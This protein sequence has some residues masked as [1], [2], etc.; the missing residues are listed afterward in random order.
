[1]RYASRRLLHGA[2]VVWA[3]YTVTWLL[4]YLLPSDPVSLMLVG[5]GNSSGQTRAALE[6][7]YGLDRPPLLQY[8]TLLG[9]ALLGD[10]GDSI[11]YGRPVLDVVLGAVPYTIQLGVAAVA[12]SIVVGFGLALLANATR[13]AWLRNILFSLPSAFLSFP[14]FLTGLLLVQIFAFSL[15]LL[16]AVG[17][18]GWQSLVLPALTSGVPASAAIAQVATKSIHEYLDSPQSSYLR[19]R[20]VTRRRILI[21]HALR[22]A[23]I[24]AVTIL[25][26][27]VGG[28]PRRCRHHR[29]RLLPPGPGEGAPERCAQ[30][31]H[32]AGTGRR[33]ALRGAVRP[34]ELPGGSRLSAA[35][36]AHQEGVT[37][38]EG[39]VAAPRAHGPHPLPGGAAR[40]VEQTGAAWASHPVDGAY[41]DECAYRP[42]ARPPVA[43]DGAGSPGRSVLRALFRRRHRA[44]RQGG[45]LSRELRQP[46]L[47]LAVLLLGAVILAAFL[48]GLFA[49]QDPYATDVTD[50][51]AAPSAQHLFGTDGLGRD[52]FSRFVHGT[53]NTLIAS[54]VAVLIG[55][56][57]SSVLG[58]L[59]GYF[60]GVLDETVS[61]FVDVFLAVPGMLISLLIVTALGFGTV[62]IAIAVGVGSIAGFTRILRAEVLRVREAD[63][64]TA[65]T[66]N[67]L[68]WYR[69]LSR[70]VLPHALGPI[71]ALI[72]LQFGEA[73]LLISSLSF[74]GFGVQ[75]PEPE[76]GVIVADGR[77]YLSTAPW[78]ALIPGVL[79]ALVV[80]SANRVS[81]FVE[82]AL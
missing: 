59:A 9:R 4:L 82:R 8:L 70:H 71:I 6:E 69:T 79:I 40:T 25:G 32:P 27:Q 2:I 77:T 20:G 60:R 36:P 13:A 24:P 3:A 80:L 78:L 38:T 21:A 52:Q 30:P 44:S 75:P 68:P 42:G 45:Q 55:F 66:V 53:A 5:S 37:M 7:K 76:W 50:K 67:G 16:P 28:H 17:T 34:H 43:E 10:F 26:M 61:R 31:G 48:P 33:G 54:L 72:P 81:K 65:A 58:V 22:N 64:V 15:H 63:F 14:V 41:L 51:F 57:A 11:E 47:L 35:R 74:L 19:A 18:S 29:D 39:T 73:V 23:V 12:V 62:E 1:M 46:T 49:G 56:S